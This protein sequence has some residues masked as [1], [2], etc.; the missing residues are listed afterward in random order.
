[1]THFGTGEESRQVRADQL[2]PGV[3]LDPWYFS[4]ISNTSLI[5]QRVVLRENGYVDIWA[6]RRL[7]GREYSISISRERLV[8]TWGTL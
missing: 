8:T 3:L 1:M 4:T 7:D 6:L 2:V 5:V